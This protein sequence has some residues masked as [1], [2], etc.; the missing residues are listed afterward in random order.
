MSLSFEDLENALEE[1][2]NA[3]E[4]GAPDVALARLATLEQRAAD[5][6]LLRGER[7]RLAVEAHLGLLDLPGAAAAL[8]L[9]SSAWLASTPA[10]RQAANAEFPEDEQHLHIARGEL[11]L[12]AWDLDGARAAYE[13]IL[14]LPRFDAPFRIAHDRLALLADVAGRYEQADTHFAAANGRP[15]VRLGEEAFQA[16]VERAAAALP[17]E[18]LA[19]FDRVPL[20]VDDMPTRDL[21][22][23]G[24]QSGIDV[25]ADVLGLF[26]G[27]SDLDASGFDFPAHPAHIRIFQRNLERIAESRAH[28]A[29]EITTTLYHELG[30]ALGHDEDGVD[31][32]GLH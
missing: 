31:A 27:A 9:H 11:A 12:A 4:G 17:P 19:V 22:C 16:E 14:E 1:A 2:W 23:S 10:A 26:L 28:L 25:P 18:F 13:A 15:P 6:V 7:A 20:V 32:M 29:E 8:E 30:H 24:G 3:F 21:A 5:V